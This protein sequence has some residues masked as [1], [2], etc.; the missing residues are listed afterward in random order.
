MLP[1]INS[2]TLF[3]DIM[4]S[5]LLLVLSS[6]ET[7]DEYVVVDDLA[8]MRWFVL[9]G[10]QKNALVYPTQTRQRVKNTRHNLEFIIIANKASFLCV[11]RRMSIHVS[12]FE[13][14]VNVWIPV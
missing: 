9:S 5:I 3:E 7:C 11:V 6:S 4:F 14:I 12:N 10:L 2:T 13:V 1:F 8:N